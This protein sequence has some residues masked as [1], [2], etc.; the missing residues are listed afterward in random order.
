MAI[1]MKGA[2]V[3]VMDYAPAGWPPGTTCVVRRVRVRAGDISTDLRARRRRTIPK[4]Q[5][6]LVLDG[7]VDE[8]YGYSFIATSI[9][10]STPGQGRRPASLAPDAYRH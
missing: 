3:A 5:L 2:Q 7:L 1:R 6:A 8:V 10:V 4:D 9:D